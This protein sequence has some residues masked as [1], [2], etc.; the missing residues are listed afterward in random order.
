MATHTDGA[1][2]V[3]APHTR[4]CV[5]ASILSPSADPQGAEAAILSKR[6]PAALV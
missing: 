1:R 5:H 4:A 2:A 3:Q 6:Q